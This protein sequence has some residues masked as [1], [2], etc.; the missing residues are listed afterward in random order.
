MKHQGKIRIK[1]LS[2]RM[3]NLQLSLKIKTFLTQDY[4][5]PLLLFTTINKGFIL[6]KKIDFTSI[7]WTRLQRMLWKVWHFS[8]R[9][10]YQTRVKVILV[11]R[12]IKNNNN[13][14]FLKLES[15]PLLHSIAFIIW[16]ERW[17]F[18]SVESSNKRKILYFIFKY[19]FFKV[20]FLTF[21]T[22]IF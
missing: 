19:I 15:A 5:I 7:E 10:N 21:L 3:R 6:V 1:H 17:I 11:M 9:L 20:F 16:D 2:S 4:L 22:L 13:F 12:L 14:V 18:I 8:T